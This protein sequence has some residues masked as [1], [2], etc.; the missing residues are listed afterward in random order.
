MKRD[1]VVW[2][3]LVLVVLGIAFVIAAT[4]GGCSAPIASPSEFVKLADEIAGIKAELARTQSQ[5]TGSMA[6]G[7]SVWGWQGFL[8]NLL[9]GLTITGPIY[10][11]YARRRL[12]E[13]HGRRRAEP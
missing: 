1:L 4:T 13:R 5:G 11:T 8:Q 2:I 12:K 6:Q 7:P 9:A 3:L 10:V